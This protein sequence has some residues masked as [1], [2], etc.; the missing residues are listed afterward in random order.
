MTLKIPP[1]GVP[2]YLDERG[3]ARVGESRVTPGP[4]HSPVV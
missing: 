4:F 2:L 3:S 1:E